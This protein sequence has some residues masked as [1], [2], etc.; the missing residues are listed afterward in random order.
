[1]DALTGCLA[2]GG[3]FVVPGLTSDHYALT[4]AVSVAGGIIAGSAAKLE[5]QGKNAK[6]WCM[7][8]MGGWRGLI[9]GL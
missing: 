4:L 1:M 3:C 8:S 5:P 6:T 2:K 7:P 9:A